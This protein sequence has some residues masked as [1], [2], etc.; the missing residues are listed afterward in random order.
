MLIAR[1][2]ELDPPENNIGH[3]LSCGAS[4]T[5]SAVRRSPVYIFWNRRFSPQL[6]KPNHPRCVHTAEL[7][8]PFEK[9]AEPM[10]YSRQSYGTGLPPSACLMA[11]MSSVQSSTWP[12]TGKRNIKQSCEINCFLCVEVM[13]ADGCL[14]LQP[15]A[16]WPGNKAGVTVCPVKRINGVSLVVS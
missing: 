3:H 4:C 15:L 6:F 12:S 13:M 16:V 11:A 2:A 14:G 8:T 5:I 7:A 1:R 10:P 9:I